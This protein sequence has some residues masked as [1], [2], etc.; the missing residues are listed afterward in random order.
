MKYSIR[1]TVKT[2]VQKTKNIGAS[3]IWNIFF[4]CGII[5]NNLIFFIIYDKK[6]T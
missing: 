1:L 5:H 3:P 6:Y 4:Y 2:L